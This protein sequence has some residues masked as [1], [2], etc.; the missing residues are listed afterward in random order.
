[1]KG[2]L[3]P[4]AIYRGYSQVHREEAGWWRGGAEVKGSMRAI[5]KQTQSLYSAR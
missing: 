2:P 5:D 3:S 4:A 1:M